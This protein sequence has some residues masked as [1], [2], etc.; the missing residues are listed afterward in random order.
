M[1]FLSGPS[2]DHCLLLDVLTD[3]KVGIYSTKISGQPLE[4]V[5]LPPNLEIPGIFCSIGHTILSDALPQF[6]TGLKN[7]TRIF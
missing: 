6:L 7:Y 1:S 5:L 2:R 4:D 3:L